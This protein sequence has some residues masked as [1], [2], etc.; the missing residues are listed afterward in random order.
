M[1]E[2]IKKDGE[3]LTIG[4]ASE[5][6]DNLFIHLSDYGDDYCDLTICYKA[7]EELFGGIGWCALPSSKIKN[8]INELINK[9]TIIDVRKELIKSH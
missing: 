8:I 6:I 3:I 7:T 9:T 4:S 2:D 5:T 1:F